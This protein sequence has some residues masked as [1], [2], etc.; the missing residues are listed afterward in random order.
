MTDPF[1][2]PSGDGADQPTQSFGTPPPV[3]GAP[4]PS[5]DAPS[6]DAP[7]HGAP[8]YGA[9][10]PYGAPL[11]TGGNN[12]MGVATLVLGIMSI[13]TSWTVIGGLVLGILA[14][15][16]GVLGR[17][18][19]RRGEAS[20]GGMALAGAITGGVGVLFAIIAGIVII[21]VAHDPSFKN[22]RDCLSDAS[23]QS[24]RNACQSEFSDR[25]AK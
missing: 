8:Q 3:Y 9:P 20:N 16:F 5:Y 15:V 19:A 10:P 6:Y 17:K 13:A 18:R 1:A 23:S 7:T 21:A 4:P 14:L 2:P 24:D 11:A 25:F 22:L 12:G